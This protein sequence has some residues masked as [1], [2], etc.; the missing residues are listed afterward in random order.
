VSK[1]TI[2]GEGPSEPSHRLSGPPEE[3]G[4]G[5]IHMTKL[6]EAPAGNVDMLR[7]R[8]VD[9]FQRMQ[10]EAIGIRARPEPAGVADR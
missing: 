5:P 8:S 1:T 6:I 9:W 4:G 10:E 2:Q 7:A 3:S